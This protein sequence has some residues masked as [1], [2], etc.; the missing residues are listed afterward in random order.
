MRY[1][2]IELNTNKLNQTVFG[3]GLIACLHK[4]KNILQI[5]YVLTI[6][7]S[8]H[9]NEKGVVVREFESWLEAVNFK[10]LKILHS[11]YNSGGKLSSG[12]EGS[13]FDL[14]VVVV[15]VASDLR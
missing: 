6:I 4:Q 15:F 11:S 8:N 9:S 13:S 10:T 14:V 2:V 12:L 1:T 5:T 7:L 3:I